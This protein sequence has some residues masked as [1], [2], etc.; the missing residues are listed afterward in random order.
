VGRYLEEECHR[1]LAS[2]VRRAMLSGDA[3]GSWLSSTVRLIEGGTARAATILQRLADGELTAQVDVSHSVDRD[4]RHRQRTLRLAGVVVALVALIELTGG[5]S[6]F[7]VNM[8]TVEAGL[9]GAA[10][11]MLI[12]SMRTLIGSR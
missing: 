6:T 7:G 2:E 1:L 11:V 8:F 12:A 10:L 9:A 4:A 3:M 5:A